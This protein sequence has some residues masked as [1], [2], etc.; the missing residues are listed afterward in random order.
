MNRIQ[1]QLKKRLFRIKALRWKENFAESQFLTDL[2][3]RVFD[4]R[5]N[6]YAFK[7]LFKYRAVALHGLKNLHL[8]IPKDEL[9]TEHERTKS[10]E[11]VDKLLFRL[12][13][14]SKAEKVVSFGER[15]GM[16]NAYMAKVDSGRVIHS[17]HQNQY[18][19]QLSYDLMKKMNICNLEFHRWNELSG[20][21]KADFVFISAFCGVEFHEKFVRNINEYLTS[22]CFVIVE[23]IHCN[24]SQELL[25]LKLKGLDVFDVSFDLFNIGVLI[26][27]KGMECNDY[28]L[29][30]RF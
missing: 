12:L 30:Y 17:F 24:K 5:M 25:W 18:W 14:F 28:V 29:N 6:Y 23:E 16:S 19:E 15:L 2:K 8:F 4:S 22:E 27:K 13:N 10:G 3:S 21:G 1:Y 7:D 9:K 20:F 26:A 11:G